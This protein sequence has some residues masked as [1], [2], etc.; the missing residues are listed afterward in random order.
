M[1]NEYP[2]LPSSS[3]RIRMASDVFIKGGSDAPAGVVDGGAGEWDLPGMIGHGGWM[4][5]HPVDWLDVQQLPS[6]ARHVVGLASV[7]DPAASS[8][9]TTAIVKWP[10]LGQPPAPGQHLHY[11]EEVDPRFTTCTMCRKV[12]KDVTIPG[13][14]V[15][16]R[17]QASSG[18]KAQFKAM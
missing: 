11:G 18:V 4:E 7:L 16:V 10:N 17:M 12:T 13:I 6:C 14:N 8:V 15:H 5:V 9:D 2:A 3:V 1:S